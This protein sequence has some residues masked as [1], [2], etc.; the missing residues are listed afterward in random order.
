MDKILSYL[1]LSSEHIETSPP[2]WMGLLV[3]MIKYPNTDYAQFVE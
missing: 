3:V 2:L 1:F